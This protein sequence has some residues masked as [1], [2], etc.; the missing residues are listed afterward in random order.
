MNKLFK[1]ASMFIGGVVCC[2][3]ATSC[4]TFATSCGRGGV[5][6]NNL[7]DEY[8]LNHRVSLPT[9]VS[10]NW[11]TVDNEQMI[12]YFNENLTTQIFINAVV[13]HAA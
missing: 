12:E 4:I 1:K 9:P 7:L 6:S 13:G 8:L 10:P 11:D 5:I 3:A 2:L